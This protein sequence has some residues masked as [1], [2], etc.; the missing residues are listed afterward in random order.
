M[1][2]GNS[3]HALRTHSMKHSTHQNRGSKHTQQKLRPSVDMDLA[4][5][6]L[7][8][9]LLYVN[10]KYSCS[11]VHSYLHYSNSLKTKPAT[12]VLP[13]DL[14]LVVCIQ[15][16]LFRKKSLFP[17][18]TRPKKLGRSVFFGFFCS[19]VFASAPCVVCLQ[20]G[21]RMSLI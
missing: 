10:V 16:K 5:Q 6:L 19:F 3:L 1:A 15:V 13:I 2:E 14:S 9:R 17:D 21:G 4:G 12:V 18:L 11:T 8:L 7:Q 20:D